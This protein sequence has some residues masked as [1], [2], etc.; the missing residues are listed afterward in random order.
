MD[1]RGGGCDRTR[2]TP[3]LPFEP[4]ASQLREL[5]RRSGDG[6]DVAL[7]WRRRDNR[8]IVSVSDAKTGCAFDIEVRESARALDVFHH[9][10]AYAARW[11]VD[12]ASPTPEEMPWAA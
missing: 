12:T 7:L 2:M 8:L 9:P 11:G 3:I 6:I 5:D 1:G 4:P 10:Y